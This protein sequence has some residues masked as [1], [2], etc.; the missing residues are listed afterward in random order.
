MSKENIV[1]SIKLGIDIGTTNLK[2]IA[3]DN[4]LE[5]VARVQKT[6]ITY[7][8][9]DRF[10]EQ[11]VEDIY[12]ALIDGL[13]EISVLVSLRQVASISFSSAMHSLILLDKEFNFISQNI[14]WSDNRASDLVDKFKMEADWL[15]YYE[16]TGTPVHP[17]SPFAKLM[18]FKDNGVLADAEYIF[19]IKEYLIFRL[20]GEYISDYSI[21]SATGLMNIHKLEWDSAALD[22]LDLN[23][24]KLPKLVD[25]DYKT[26]L[27]NPE[28]KR[29]LHLNKDIKIVIGGSDGSLTNLGANVLTE[30]DAT[31]TIGTSAAIRMTAD[32]PLLDKEGRLFS[33][34]IKDGKWLIGGAS[35]NGGNVLSWLN[36][37]MF[38]GNETVFDSLSL[39]ISETSIG[40]DGLLFLPFLNGERAP[41]WDADLR[42]SFLGLQSSHSKNDLIRAI[43]EGMFF[44]IKNIKNLLEDAMGKSIGNIYVNGGLAENIDVMTLLA[45]LLGSDLN[46]FN[47]TDLTALGAVKITTDTQAAA[48]IG[49]VL[50]YNSSKHKEYLLRQDKFN[51]LVDLIAEIYG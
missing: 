10:V 51:K 41:Y 37:V 44:N 47:A 2:I 50:E 20:S 6:Y 17:M 7:F 16:A 31:L 5:Q 40:A 22:Y 15:S 21:A 23:E 33:Y 49:Q 18:W 34:Y 45:D 43:L 14:I 19:G 39:A 8:R 12:A 11:E 30:G 13:L 1:E 28:V 24:A 48:V 26:S 38:S 46:I 25:V 42:A 9:E 36:R 4:E 32:S 29:I 27:N 3:F 35:N